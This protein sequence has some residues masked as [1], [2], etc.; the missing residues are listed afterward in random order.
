MNEVVNPVGSMFARIAGVYDFLNHFLS[1]GI[2]RYW[3]RELTKLV[4]YGQT[5][6]IPDLAAGTLDVALGVLSRYPEAIIP[7][8]DFCPEM[9]ARGIKKLNTRERKQ[10]IQPCTADILHLPMQDNSADSVTIAFGIRNISDRK[11][12]FREMARV[13]VPGGRACILEFG[14]GRDK[15]WGGIYNFYLGRI[16]PGI[17]KFFS[18]G[19][20]AYSYLAET[21]KIFPAAE[22]LAGEMLEAGF[23]NVGYRRLTSG[24]V[25]L[26]WGD[27]PQ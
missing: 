4:R 9:L 20:S 8:F 22:E 27:K 16:L 11:T 24:I 23:E 2:D 12:A 5:G 3:R 15:I 26:H 17:G 25:C 18:T 14:S 7:A 21:I 1:V 19:D 6:I 13:L 10:K